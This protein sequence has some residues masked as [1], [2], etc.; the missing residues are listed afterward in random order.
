MQTLT[1]SVHSLTLMHDDP[2]H[3]K[4][5]LHTQWNDS[6]ELVQIVSAVQLWSPASQKLKSVLVM[7]KREI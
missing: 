5:G 7:R 3:L 6:R 2:V 4:P 1:L